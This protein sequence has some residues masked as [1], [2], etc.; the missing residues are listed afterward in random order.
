MTRYTQPST[1]YTKD[2]EWVTVHNDLATVGITHYA[3]NALGDIVFVELPEVGTEFAPGDDMAVV[4]SVKAASDVYAPIH[5]KVVEV[6]KT[7][8]DKPETVNESPDE[9]GWFCILKITDPGDIAGLMDEEAYKEYCK[10]L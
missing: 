1:F 6:N 2:H 4:E 7:L 8:T 5:G 3:E 9:K 10:T